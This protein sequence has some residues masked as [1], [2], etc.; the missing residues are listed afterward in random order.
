MSNINRHSAGA[1]QAG[2]SVGGQFA[3]S[4]KT[5]ASGAG[6]AGPVPESVAP[7]LLWCASTE[8]HSSHSRANQFGGEDHCSGMPEV[9]QKIM[10]ETLQQ[11]GIESHENSSD[12]L[13]PTAPNG[14]TWRIEM[15]DIPTSS[16]REAK[17]AIADQIE[18]FDADELFEELWDEGEVRRSE[19][20]LKPSQFLGR[21]QADE[22]YFKSKAA[23]LRGEVE[24]PHDTA[25]RIA[26]KYPVALET[27]EDIRDAMIEAI[28]ADR[29]LRG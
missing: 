10:K 29:A 27:H 13:L 19:P 26:L 25:T 21:L 24:S 5:E 7:A 28:E 6:L 18:Q 11:Y 14:G 23:E 20:G 9:N 12:H 17:L 8:P 1:K 15:E 4:Q 16:R 22:R 3:A 2:Q